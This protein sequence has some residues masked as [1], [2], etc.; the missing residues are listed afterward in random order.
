MT[1]RPLPA[2]TPAAQGVDADGVQAFLDAVEAAPGIEAHSL[3]IVRHGR[4]VAAGWWAPYTAERKHLLYSLSKSFTSAAAG[5]AVADG[6]L[7]LDATVVS[8]FPEFE[9]EITDLGSRAMLVRHIA[10]MASGHTAETYRQAA[11][12]DPAELVRGFLLLPPERAPG[13]V[14]AYNQPATYTLGT[15]IQRATGGTL[16][17]YL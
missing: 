3:I 12:T 7:D 1:V 14:F 10:S 16:T 13:T 17:E 15:I 6:L 8:Y 4:Q 9:A 5:L 11:R 2:D